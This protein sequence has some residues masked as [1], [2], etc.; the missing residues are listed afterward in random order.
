MGGEGRCWQERPGT[1]HA[2]QGNASDIFQP[3][4]SGQ[5]GFMGPPSPTMISVALNCVSP[6][7][8]AG[9]SSSPEAAGSLGHIWRL[10]QHEC[11][12]LTLG[13]HQTR[14]GGGVGWGGSGGSCP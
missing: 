10:A 13:S 4:V 14:E 9:L 6:L 7:I 5:P 8:D 3:L 12:C 1:L 2:S 11:P